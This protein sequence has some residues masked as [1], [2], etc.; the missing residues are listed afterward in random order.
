MVENTRE[1]RKVIEDKH[2]ELPNTIS[3]SSVRRTVSILLTTLYP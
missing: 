3:V 2:I 1:M